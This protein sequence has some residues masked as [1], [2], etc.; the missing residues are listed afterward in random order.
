M[1]RATWPQFTVVT[2]LTPVLLFTQEMAGWERIDLRVGVNEGLG[3]TITS[4]STSTSISLTWQK[5]KPQ[6]PLKLKHLK[7]SSQRRRAALIE[8]AAHTVRR[9]TRS[10]SDAASQSSHAMSEWCLTSVQLVIMQ[11]H[12]NVKQKSPNGWWQQDICAFYWKGSTFTD[13]SFISIKIIKKHDCYLIRRV[14]CRVGNFP[15]PC[16]ALQTVRMHQAIA[17]A[18]AVSKFDS[19]FG[20]LEGETFVLRPSQEQAPKL[21]NDLHWEKA[22]KQNSKR[23]RHP[24][25]K[26]KQTSSN[27]WI[28]Q[29]NK[30]HAITAA[31]NMKII[32]QWK[33]THKHNA[34]EKKQTTLKKTCIPTLKKQQEHTNNASNKTHANKKQKKHIKYQHN[35]FERNANTASE[36]LQTE[37][38]KHTNNACKIWCTPKSKDTCKK[39]WRKTRKE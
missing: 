36:K 15:L 39:C 24:Q 27:Q 2:K 22:Y 8:L 19:T 32:Q 5:A 11:R 34:L 30:I 13:V 7:P 14:K 38:E 3:T 4:S 18:S 16:D 33:E 29:T 25:K 9:H 21:W 31:Q 37:V 12:W 6:N 17:S 20:L 26:C 28:N 23:I 10:A 1:Q 35:P